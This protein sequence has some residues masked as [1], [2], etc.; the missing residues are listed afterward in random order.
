MHFIPKKTHT[1]GLGTMNIF[2]ASKRPLANPVE[3]TH[4]IPPDSACNPPALKCILQACPYTPEALQSTHS[5]LEV[6]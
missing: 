3:V 1:G 6:L 4:T 5:A 2:D